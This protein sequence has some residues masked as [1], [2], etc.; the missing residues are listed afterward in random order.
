MWQRFHPLT[1]GW[2]ILVPIILAK[3]KVGRS[4]VVKRRY[5]SAGG[6]VTPGVSVV[7]LL[8]TDGYWRIPLRFKLWRPGEGSHVDA[9][10]ELLS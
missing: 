3:S 6:Y 10:L 2:L 5:R 7:M 8:W 1:H 9:A 4:P